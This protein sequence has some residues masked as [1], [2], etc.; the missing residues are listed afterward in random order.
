M[1]EKDLSGLTKQDGRPQ[2][3]SQEEFVVEKA[4][5]MEWGFTFLLFGL[6]LFILI[7][8]SHQIL[9]LVA[10]GAAFRYAFCISRPR[11]FILNKGLVDAK[12]DKALVDFTEARFTAGYVGI[13]D[14]EK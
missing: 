5:K 10:V 7:G 1:I 9:G 4:T 2:G 13:F 12:D 14:D 6:A 3:I 8:T 11:T